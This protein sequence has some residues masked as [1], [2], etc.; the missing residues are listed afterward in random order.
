MTFALKKSCVLCL[1]LC[2]C[3]NSFLVSFNSRKSLSQAVLATQNY[4]EKG[5]ETKLSM[6]HRVCIRNPKLPSIISMAMW[7]W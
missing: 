5:K 1:V 4:S 6:H 2:T 7:L 3:Y